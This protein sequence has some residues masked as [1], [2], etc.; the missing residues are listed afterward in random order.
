MSAYGLIPFIKAGFLRTPVAAAS[1]KVEDVLSILGDW[2]AE[3]W[4]LLLR[5]D[6][7]VCHVASSG[8]QVSAQP[9]FAR[10]EEDSMESN[11]LSSLAK[12][13]GLSL[14]AW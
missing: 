7:G 13:N 14:T 10:R 5:L 11:C 4:V 2:R 1:P 3:V 12:F 6:D 8:R 9:C